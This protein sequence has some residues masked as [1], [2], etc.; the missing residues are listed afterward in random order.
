[1]PPR[2]RV[3][4]NR[5]EGVDENQGSDGFLTW[6]GESQHLYERLRAEAL[7]GQKTLSFE[8]WGMSLFLPGY[9]KRPFWTVRR[10]RAP[11]CAGEFSLKEL[12]L[13]LGVIGPAPQISFKEVSL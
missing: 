13:E 5:N 7:S 10:L 11:V 4:K 3:K 12:L 2:R 1:M 9:S 6:G 8:D